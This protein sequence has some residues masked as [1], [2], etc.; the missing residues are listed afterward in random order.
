MSQPDDRQAA[1]H[2]REPW[3]MKVIEPFRSEGAAFRLV[4][5]VLA[6]CAG[7]RAA[8]ADRP[9]ALSEPGGYLTVSLPTMPP[10]RWPGTAQK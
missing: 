9:L 7:D 8:G 3:S 1:D 6:I 4:L 10:S 5:W 2:E